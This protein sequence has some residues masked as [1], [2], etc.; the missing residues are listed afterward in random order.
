MRSSSASMAC[1]PDE[2]LAAM[3]ALRRA[4]RNP[5]YSPSDLLRDLAAK[6]LPELAARLGGREDHL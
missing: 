6:G 4:Y 3:R 2:V 5:S 1:T